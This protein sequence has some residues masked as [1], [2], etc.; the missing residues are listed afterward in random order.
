MAYRIVGRRVAKVDAREKVTGEARYSG[1]IHLPGTF[2]GMILTRPVPHARLIN[3][4]TSV[5]ESLPG[6]LAVVTARDAVPWRIGLF[7]RGRTPL[8]S[9]KVRYIGEPVAEVAAVDQATAEVAL[10]R[11]RV[12]YE[13][14]PAVFALGEALQPGAPASCLEA[15]C[16]KLDLDWSHWTPLCRSLDK[17]ALFDLQS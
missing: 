15:P 9:G 7:I 5:A 6:V 2:Q 14:L 10:S 16:R 3:V 13:E 12:T 4:D 11:I 1:D 17:H 8:A